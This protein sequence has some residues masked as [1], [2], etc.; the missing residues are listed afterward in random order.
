MAIT[1]ILYY[2]P[3][4]GD[5]SKTFN[6]FAIHKPTDDIR[7]TDIEHH[8]PV[9]G[10]YHFRFQFKYRGVLVWLDLSNKN[11]KLPQVDGIIMI[12]A[13]RNSWLGAGE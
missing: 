13:L 3:E 6:C 9:A 8:F 1:N 4:D 12:K 11:G 7:L 10:N 5:D 2:I